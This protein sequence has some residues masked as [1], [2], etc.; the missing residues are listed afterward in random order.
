MAGFSQSIGIFGATGELGRVLLLALEQQAA[1]VG[2]VRVFASERSFEETIVFR[3]RPLSVEDP[4]AA[5]LADLSEAFL[6]V[7]AEVADELAERL[8]AQGTRVWDCS[9]SLRA[10][11][12]AVGLL[13]ADDDASLIVVE[14]PWFGIVLP[15]I[16]ALRLRS[17]ITSLRLQLLSPV[18]VRGQ[19]GV[20]ELASQ[21]GHLLNGRGI[22]P[23]VWPVQVAFNALLSDGSCSNDGHTSRERRL[24]KLL[25]ERLGVSDVHVEQLVLPIFYGG[26]VQLSWTT[27]A[28]LTAQDVR[29]AWADLP[30]PYEWFA[31]DELASPVGL[32]AEEEGV[33]LARLHQQGQQGQIWLLADALRAGIASPVVRNLMNRV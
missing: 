7:P 6:A 25:I 24:Q 1:F 20:K 18:A 16:E 8:L 3:D 2:R 19:A 29:Q 32:G 22:E 33:H 11:P 27:E 23:S 17:P 26:L 13:A 28:S 21:T 10:H 12:Q 5:D 4:R 14:D 31:A 30:Q 15:L 9:A